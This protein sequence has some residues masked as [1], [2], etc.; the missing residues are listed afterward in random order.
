MLMKELLFFNAKFEVA[1]QCTCKSTSWIKYL[2]NDAIPIFCEILSD[3]SNHNNII[4]SKAMHLA[5]HTP[6]ERLNRAP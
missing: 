6:G 2:F 4:S 5:T 3:I 1:I